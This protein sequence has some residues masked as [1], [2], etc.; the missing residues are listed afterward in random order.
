MDPHN[1]LV[2]DTGRHFL[3]SIKNGSL[4]NISVKSFEKV[5]RDEFNPKYDPADENDFE[6]VANLLTDVYNF[7]DNL[8]PEKHGL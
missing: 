4:K 1:K 7:Y 6:S 3:Q 2:L 5:M 8:K